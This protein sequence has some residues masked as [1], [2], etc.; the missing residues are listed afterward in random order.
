MWIVTETLL[1]PFSRDLPLGAHRECEAHQGKNRHAA[2]L[3]FFVCVWKLASVSSWFIIN[4]T[5]DWPP[6]LFEPFWRHAQYCRKWCASDHVKKTGFRQG[7]FLEIGRRQVQLRRCCHVRAM[8]GSRRKQ[9]DTVAL[10]SGRRR[11]LDR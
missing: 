2:D 10:G 1:P 5:D 8:T 7:G 4:H 6:Q 9:N 11:G 3:I